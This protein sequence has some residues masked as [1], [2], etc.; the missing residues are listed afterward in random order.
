MDAHAGGLLLAMLVAGV[1]SGVHC[2]GMCGGI[3]AVFGA[4]RTIPVV[5]AGARTHPEFVRQLGFNAGRITSYTIGG[6]LA[7]L[8]GSTALYMAGARPAQTVLYM[9]ANAMLVLVGLYLAGAG[10]LLGPLER[11]GAPLWRRVQ[12][13]AARSLGASTLPQTY[14]AGLL[15]GFLPCGL[16]YG[17]LAA[18]AFAGSAGAGAGAMLAFGLGTLPNLL[19]AGLLA[20]RTRALLAHRAARLGAGAVVLGFGVA[21]LMG[22]L[23]EKQ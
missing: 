6:A 14:A 16:V 11:L 5:A 22:V 7:G 20:A 15:W 3:V 21:G 18:A 8:L 4:R 23:G 19:A 13:I 9:L 12:P 10:R 1:A 2:L 17:A